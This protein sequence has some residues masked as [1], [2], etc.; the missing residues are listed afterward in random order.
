MR[1]REVTI[2]YTE[3][4]RVRGRECECDRSYVVS[5]HGER[6]GTVCV[7]SESESE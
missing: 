1:V 3:R 5:V 2:V 7:H 6:Y 4:E